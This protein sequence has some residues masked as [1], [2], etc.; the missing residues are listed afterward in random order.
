MQTHFTKSF[1]RHAF[2]LIELL[3]VIAVIAI[4]AALLLPALA[5][6]KQQAWRSTCQNNVRQLQLGWTMYANDFGDILPHNSVGTGAGESLKN[7]GWCAGIMWL[8]S[9]T[10]HDITMSTNTD[11]LVGDQY[12]PFGSIGGYVKNPAIYHCPGDRSTVTITGQVLPRARSMSMNGYMGAPIQNPAFREF[13]K[14]QDMIVPGPSDAWVFIDERE[15]SI[16]DGLFAVDAGA[17]YAIVDYPGDY[18][19]GGSCLSFADG[20]MEYHKWLEP[21]TNPPLR[22]GQRMPGGSIPTSPN[23]RDMAWLVARTTSRN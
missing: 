6:S 10:G 23:D 21:T 14:M 16:N 8:N 15:D 12:A 5:K 3:V 4:L 18:H 11:L 2:T 7:I 9:D 19:G 13:M 17:H 1:V 20:H 22:V